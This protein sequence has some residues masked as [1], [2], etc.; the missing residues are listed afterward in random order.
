MIAVCFTKNSVTLILAQSLCQGILYHWIQWCAQNCLRKC[1]C[2]PTPLASIWRGEEE[3]ISNQLGASKPMI[4]VRTTYSIH[5]AQLSFIKVQFPIISQFW[6]THMWKL[7]FSIVSPF[8]HLLLVCVVILLLFCI[9]SSLRIMVIAIVYI[10]N[11]INCH[12]QSWSSYRMQL[13]HLS[14]LVEVNIGR[15][16]HD[17]CNLRILW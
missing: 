4:I 17:S 11:Y 7:V 15:V 6:L 3:D 9:K 13:G 14:L 2:S 12:M 16:Y 1:L 10:Y 8:K 5:S